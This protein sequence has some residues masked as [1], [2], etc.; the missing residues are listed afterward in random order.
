MPSRSLA[1]SRDRLQLFLGSRPSPSLPLF[2][3]SWPLSGPKTHP[4]MATN[5]IYSGYKQH[6]AVSQENGRVADHPDYLH[7]YFESET[8][9]LDGDTPA[10][11]QPNHRGSN[12]SQSSCRPAFP[13]WWIACERSC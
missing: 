12:L 1:T 11:Y 3:A 8:I 9:T 4:M 13:R 7:V 5:V 6:R 10:E 2:C